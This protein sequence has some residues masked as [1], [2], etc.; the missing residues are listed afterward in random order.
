MASENGMMSQQALN[1]VNDGASVG[2][3]TATS[4]APTEEQKPENVTPIPGAA[5]SLVPEGDSLLSDAGVGTPDRAKLTAAI[6]SA[7]SEAMR[8]ML[9]GMSAGAEGADVPRSDFASPAVKRL[10][11]VAR[12]AD[13]EESFASPQ[14]PRPRPVE[15]PEFRTGVSVFGGD[16]RMYTRKDGSTV[17][18]GDNVDV[19]DR[20]ATAGFVNS[21][22]AFADAM[23][24]IYGMEG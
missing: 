13:Y 20:A 9:R 24:R 3:A 17:D 14:T 12:P 23:D 7:K 4:L 18:I 15:I 1:I 10:A 8:R 19:N 16:S 21:V 11:S 5:S 22:N 2:D 6:N